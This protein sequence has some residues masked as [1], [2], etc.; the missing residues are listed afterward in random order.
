MTRKFQPYTYE[1]VESILNARYK[2]NKTLGSITKDVGRTYGSL[3]HVVNGLLEYKKGNLGKVPSKPLLEMYKRYL[4]E[5]ASD[6]LVVTNPRTSTSGLAKRLEETFG[7]QKEII[8]GLISQEAETQANAAIAPVMEELKE[9]REFKQK[10][11][12]MTFGDMIRQVIK[13]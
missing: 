11:E 6:S 1:E 13:H 8:T 3:H 9:L 12:K 2:E 7:A 5:S 10:A 4:E